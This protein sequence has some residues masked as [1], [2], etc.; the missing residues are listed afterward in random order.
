MKK[1]WG[2]IAIAVAILLLAVVLAVVLV[3]T[4]Q[5]PEQKAED[6]TE[7]L[8]EVMPVVEQS[9]SYQIL[10]Q[11]SVQPRVMTHI[12]SEV[13]G[14]ITFVADAFYEGGFFKKGDLLVQIEQFDYQ[15]ALKLAEANLARAQAQLE[16]EKARGK[17]AEKEWSM[18]SEGK[19]PKLGLRLPQLAQ[20][21]ANVRSMEAELASAK[22]NL[23]RTEI[24]APF[25]GLVKAKKASLG[26][27][28]SRGTEVGE[29][30]ATAVAE[31]RLPLT[32]TDLAYLTLPSAGRHITEYPAVELSAEIAGETKRWPA[33][34]VRTEGVL[35]EQNRVI[36]A[37]A[38]LDDPYQLKSTSG[39]P[40]RFGRFVKA[41]IVGK[42]AENI[43]LVPRHLLLPNQRVLTLSADEQLD[44]RQVTVQRMD[45]NYA[46]V[47]QG[48]KSTDNLVLTAIS[49]PLQGMQLKRVSKGD[50]KASVEGVL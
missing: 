5:P 23:Q 48:L 10:S 28:I 42:Q 21:L 16:E 29:V 30:F 43:V 34:L 22:R 8:V 13:T 49:N 7:L 9:L 47:S 45:E 50:M 4:K 2:K 46:Y 12:T 26:Q 20:E 41:R 33:H 35:D 18:F 25:D 1:T 6:K 27:F 15:T 44:I 3:S 40:L 37:V 14:V 24:R 11:G 39:T 36:Y 19:A 31:I 32:D 38:Q 17:V